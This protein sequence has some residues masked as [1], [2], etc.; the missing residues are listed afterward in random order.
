MTLSIANPSASFENVGFVDTKQALLAICPD[1][2]MQIADDGGVTFRQMPG[3]AAK[4][5]TELVYKLANSPVRVTIRSYPEAI[6]A[7]AGWLLVCEVATEDGQPAVRTSAAEVLYNAPQAPTE[8]AIRYDGSPNISE[9]HPNTNSIYY[10]ELVPLPGGPT[11]MP[12]DDSEREPLSA[13]LVHLLAHALALTTGAFDASAPEA[14]ALTYE[15]RYRREHS[16]RARANAKLIRRPVV[17]YDLGGAECFIATAAYGSAY[18]PEVEKLRQFRNNVLLN[19]RTGQAF[20]RRFYRQYYR[21]SPA[22]A[23]AME[24]EPE[25]KEVMRWAVVPIVRYLEIALDFPEAS[26]EGVPEPWR[27]F[28]LGVR[29]DLEAWISG[30]G[31]P[32]DFSGMPPSA[33]AS[34]LAMAL[35][36]MLRSEESRR[37]YVD[38]LIARGRLPIRCG[39]DDYQAFRKALAAAGRTEGEIDRLVA[40]AHEEADQ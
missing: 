24:R 21:F 20:F 10:V 14:Y 9:Q 17:V 32:D 13:F 15:N 36:Y 28:I 2:G 18:E 40:M 25:T 29:Q 1:P 6:V 31:L 22:I 30:V 35:R 7:P 16:M 12:T 11:D 27:S 33:A 4:S 38:D 5:G 39:A 23:A 8:I 37:A 34:E 26:L 3:G 19:T